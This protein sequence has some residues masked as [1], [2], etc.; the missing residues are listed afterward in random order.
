MFNT[1]LTSIILLYL[2]FSFLQKHNLIIKLN[3]KFWC[4]WLSVKYKLNYIYNYNIN[5]LTLVNKANTILAIMQTKSIAATID[6]FAYMIN[7]I[8]DDMLYK[9]LN[10]FKKP[11]IGLVNMLYDLN[12]IN[13]NINYYKKL[14][15]LTYGNGVI[16]GPGHINPST[17]ITVD[18]CTAIGQV[19]YHRIVEVLNVKT[20]YIN[21]RGQIKTIMFNIDLAFI[22]P[23]P[24]DED[25]YYDF[26]YNQ[27]NILIDN[28]YKLIN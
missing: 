2:D 26:I 11:F 1:N 22:A 13:Y 24:I 27:V 7:N 16:V 18:K 15:N 8:D 25:F 10:Q 19:N 23:Q 20:E 12:F 14:F 5:Y 9:F 3:N 4:D 21:N 6:S 28:C 17:V